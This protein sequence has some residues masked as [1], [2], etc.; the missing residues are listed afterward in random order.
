MKHLILYFLVITSLL[1]SC[2]TADN[3][4]KDKNAAVAVTTKDIDSDVNKTVAKLSIEGMTCSAGCGGKIQQ[5][6]RALKGVT[7]TEL[8][9]AEDRK[10]NIVSVVYNPNEISEKDFVNCVNSIADGKYSVKTVEI[11][12][13]KSPQAKG[14]G[15]GSDVSSNNFGRVFQLLNFLQSLS[16]VIQN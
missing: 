1:L 6:L 2:S 12:N 7:T 15:G 10:E 13:Y 8:D 4:S 14:N 9:F 11:L 3:S 5:D 16:S